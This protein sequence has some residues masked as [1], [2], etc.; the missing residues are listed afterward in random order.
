M[1]RLPLAAALALTLAACATTSETKGTAAGAKAPATPAQPASNGCSQPKRP[2]P[3]W[4]TPIHG[5]KLTQ[6]TL[7]ESKPLCSGTSRKSC[8]LA[9]AVESASSITMFS[10]RESRAKAKGSLVECSRPK[11]ERHEDL[12]QLPCEK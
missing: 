7:K 8:P 12:R 4:A 1:S 9:C 5:L 3:K 10:S 2:A 6:V 11:R